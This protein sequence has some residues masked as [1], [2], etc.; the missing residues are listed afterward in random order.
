VTII[1]VSSLLA[2][3]VVMLGLFRTVADRRRG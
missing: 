3:L 1:V 2:L